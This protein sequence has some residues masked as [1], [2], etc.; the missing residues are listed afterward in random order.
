ML[1]HVGTSKVL[2]FGIESPG[3]WS[4]WCVLGFGC[5]FRSEAVMIRDVSGFF[6]FGRL[7]KACTQN[8]LCGKGDF[9]NMM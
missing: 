7:R 6:S 2:D 3:L 5:S 1:K 8:I 4:H 9:S